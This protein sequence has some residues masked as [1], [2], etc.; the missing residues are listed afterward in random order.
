MYICLFFNST[1]SNIPPNVDKEIIDSG[2]YNSSEQLFLPD[3]GNSNEE[4]SPITSKSTLN[5]ITNNLENESS[6]IPL[7]RRAREDTNNVKTVIDYLEKK[8]S[9]KQEMDST[10]LLFLSYSKILKS[11]SKTRQI[12]IKKKLA[13]IFSD[14][15]FEQVLEDETEPFSSQSSVPNIYTDTERQR[16]SNLEFEAESSATSSMPFSTHSDEYAEEPP[17]QNF[18]KKYSLWIEN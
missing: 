1:S 7:K 8:R 4:A 5:E 16:S 11:F 13:N 3:I 2:R 9:L 18:Q 15:E 17:V 10:D 14:A 12:L 6:P